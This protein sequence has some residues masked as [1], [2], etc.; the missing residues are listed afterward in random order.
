[1]CSFKGCG[2]RNPR[3]G[4]LRPHGKQLATGRETS[5]VRDER[6]PDGVGERHIA[7]DFS[8]FILFN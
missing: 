1:M 6:R 8:I 4:V 3:S 7:S 2:W 5:V